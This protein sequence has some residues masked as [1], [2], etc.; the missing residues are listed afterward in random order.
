M[1]IYPIILCGGSG[2]RLWPLS[3]ESHPKQ[4]LPLLRGRSPF[5]ATLQRLQGLADS[6]PT[7]IIANQEHLFMVQ[8]QAKAVGIESY[9]LYIEPCGRGTAPAV[10]VAAYQLVREDSQAAMLVMPAD[11]D[12]PDHDSFRR[13]IAQGVAALHAERLVVFGLAA[14]R[15][16][17]GY[18]Y[19]ERGMPLATADGCYQVARFTEKPELEIAQGFVAS[20][21]HYWNSGIFLFGAAQFI[22][23]LERFEPELA[24]ACRLAADSVTTEHDTRRIGADAFARCRTVSVDH[25]VLEHTAAAAM[26][27]ADFPWSDIGSWHS[28]WDNAEKDQHG[29]VTLGDTYLHEVTDSYV[30]S[31]R[32]MVV[33]IGLKDMVIVETADALLVAAREDVQHVKE[34]VELLRAQERDECRTHLCVN[35]PWGHYED[36]DGGERFRVKRLTVNPGARLSLQLH[37][38]RAEHWVVVRGTARVTRDEEVVLLYEN[39][40]TY[41]PVGVAHRLE[42]P[43]KIP[44]EVIE[45]QSGSYLKEDDIVRLQDAYHRV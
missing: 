5:E 13:A 9:Q 39:Q 11:H 42:N 33:G 7:L 28:L 8:D 22:A 30:H 18:G 3:R 27:A 25:A 14:R 15:A 12:I 35:R 1:N 10:A 21:Q 45:T 36:I 37:H 6:Q 4:F 2:T 17:T 16:E 31:S 44:L 34:A 26:V 24:S 29:N 38:H 43:G 23:E 32:R 40:S 20:G 19:I 41:I